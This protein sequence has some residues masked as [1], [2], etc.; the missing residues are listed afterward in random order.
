MSNYKNNK[1]VFRLQTSLK[2]TIYERLLKHGYESREAI[3]DFMVAAA[4]DR[5]DRLDALKNAA[6]TE[7]KGVK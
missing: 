4:L 6:Q 5:L 3:N 2:Y 1:V 7:V